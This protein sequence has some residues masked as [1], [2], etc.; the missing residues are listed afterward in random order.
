VNELE[1]ILNYIK[2]NLAIE[3]NNFID[4]II[5]ENTRVENYF[6]VLILK[7][8]SELKSKKKI[9][10]Y[11]FQYLLKI[12]NNKRKHIDFLIVGKDFKA[13]LEI[14]HL[15]ID[16]EVKEKNKRTINFYTSNS[17]T[18]KKVGIIGD[19]EKLNTIKNNDIT[20][21]ISFSIAT[22]PPEQKVLNERSKFLRKQDASKNWNIESQTSDSDKLSFIVCRKTAIKSAK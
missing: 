3:R 11:K 5:V 2:T 16:S 19:L 14:K 7:A 6:S 17:T 15:A 18:G 12:P 8:L 9:I 20:D 10:H 1:N 21:F 13:Y 22:N 4:L